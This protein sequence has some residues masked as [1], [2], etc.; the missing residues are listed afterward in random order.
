MVN[1]RFNKYKRATSFD[2]KRP[3]KSLHSEVYKNIH[4]VLKGIQSVTGRFKYLFRCSTTQTPYIIFLMVK[5][6]KLKIKYFSKAALDHSK[7]KSTGKSRE[8]AM[9]KVTKNDMAERDLI[10]KGMRLAEFFSVFLFPAILFFL[11]FYLMGFR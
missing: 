3:K 1:K 7:R 8:G 6:T 4:N 2:R 10:K 11:L 9:K 5:K